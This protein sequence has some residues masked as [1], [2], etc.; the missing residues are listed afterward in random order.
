MSAIDLGK[1]VENRPDSA[2]HPVVEVV[3]DA[4]DAGVARVEPVARH[5]L[6]DVVDQLA[7][8]ERVEK[9]RERPEVERGGAGAEQ[10]VADPASSQMITRMYWQRGVSSMPSSFST[11]WCQATS[12]IGGLM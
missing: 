3:Q 6:V 7:L 4:A 8:V 5:L 12:F 9:G 11:A 1:A 10:V 2:E